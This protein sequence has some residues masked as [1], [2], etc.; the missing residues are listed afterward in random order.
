[1][2]PGFLQERNPVVRVLQMGPCY[3]ETAPLVLTSL[4]F[5]RQKMT[6]LGNWLACDITHST[7]CW[8]HGET[9]DP[10]D[11]PIC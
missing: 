1:M 3:M 10:P 7:Q 8:H 9:T 6:P 5:H 11:I 2:I 4:P